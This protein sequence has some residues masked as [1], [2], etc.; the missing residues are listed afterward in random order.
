MFRGEEGSPQLIHLEDYRFDPEFFKKEEND[1]NET[2]AAIFKL[3]EAG[4][5]NKELPDLY[6]RLENH[7]NGYYSHGFTFKGAE[8]IGGSL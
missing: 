1:G 6:I 5:G 4:W 7:H 2:Y 8:T 3:V